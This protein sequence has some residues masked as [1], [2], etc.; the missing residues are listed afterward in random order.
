MRTLSRGQRQVSRRYRRDTRLTKQKE[1]I[2]AESK[3][4]IEGMEGTKTFL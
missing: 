2:K 1:E 3:K 4:G